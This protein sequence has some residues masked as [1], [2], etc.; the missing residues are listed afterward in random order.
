MVE[1]AIHLETRHLGFRPIGGKIPPGHACNPKMLYVWK[2]KRGL[3]NDQANSFLSAFSTVV[4]DNQFS[5]LGVVLLAVLA[6]LSK[7][8]GI[9]HQKMEPATTK[10]RMTVAKE[11]LGERIRRIDNAPLAPVKISHADSKVSRVSK[12]KPTEKSA[13]Y[14]ESTEDGVSKTTSK[15]KKKKKKK[16]AIDDLFSG[17]F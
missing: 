1:M 11:D 17:L 14:T 6:R 4:A 9:S 12:E 7:I 16:N 5:A 15:K 13:E 8:T 2:K 10:S 3:P